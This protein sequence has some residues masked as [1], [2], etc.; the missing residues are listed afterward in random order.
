M[1]RRE[2]LGDMLSRCRDDF[3]A[4]C[5]DGWGVMLS[6]GQLEADA[7]MGPLGPRPNGRAPKIHFISGGQRGG[8]TVYLGLKHADANVYKRG[9]DNTDPRFW[10]NYL[11]KTLAIAPSVE[12]V[13]KLYV[14]MDELSK[15]ASDA[16]WDRRARRSRGGRLIGMMRAGKQDKWPTVFYRLPGMDETAQT[17]FRTSEGRATR[18]EGGQWW[19]VTWDEWATQPP[20]EIGYVLTEVLLGRSRDHDAKIWPAA[21][22]KAESEH[23][24]I[25]VEREI[26]TGTGDVPKAITYLSSESAYFTNRQALETERLMKDEVTYK[27]TVLGRPGGGSAIEFKPDVVANMVRRRD[28]ETGNPGLRHPA[29]PDSDLPD[30]SWRY[31]C[32]WDIGLAHDETVG[33]AWAIP[34]VGVTPESKARIKEVRILPSG[35]TQTLDRIVHEMR[36]MQLTFGGRADVALDASGL[37]GVAAARQLGSVLRPPPIEFKSTGN[38]RIYGNMRLAAIT[39]A[40]EMLSWHRDPARPDKPWGLVEAPDV[41]ELTD[42]MAYFDRDAKNQPDDRVWAFIIGCWYIRRYWV[43]GDALHRQAAFDSRIIRPDRVAP[44]IARR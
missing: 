12:L 19:G 3:P 27:R 38:H 16:Q 21:W 15:G 25:A 23:H 9:V 42:Q 24:L 44:F 41:K 5:Y 2:T 17:D 4:F 10:R 20:H 36:T 7:E 32:S 18:L 13:L 8:K 40:L 22:P 29:L 37:G 14:V 11:Y 26:E 1:R 43:V 28:P 35:E 30:G 6:D 31:F 34:R 39:N 33:I